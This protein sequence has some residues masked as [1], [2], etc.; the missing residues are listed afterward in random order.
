MKFV[1]S[2]QSEPVVLGRG[3]NG[4][5]FL[6]QIDNTLV[7]IKCSHRYRFGFSLEFFIR[8]ACYLSVMS[9]SS[10]SPNFYGVCHFDICG[11]YGPLG[12]VMEY[13]GNEKDF[14]TYSKCI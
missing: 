6:G 14:K 7:A 5:V 9:A 11:A 12:M 2:S 8:E 1:Q 10:R 4:T 3:A 13:C